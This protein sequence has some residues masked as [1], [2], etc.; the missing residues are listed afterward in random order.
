MLFVHETHTVRGN[1]RREFED[2]FRYEWMPTLARGDDARLLW[3]FDH[4]HG[5]AGSNIVITTTALRGGAALARLDARVR[6]GD[7]KPWRARVDDLCDD[8]VGRTM[9]PVS[10]SLMQEVD[11]ATV[12]SN[13]EQ[14]HDHTLYIEDNGWPHGPLN[15]YIRFQEVKWDKPFREGTAN[16]RIQIIMEGFMQVAHGSGRRPECMFIEKLTEDEHALVNNLLGTEL[17]DRMR[18]P[19]GYMVEGLKLRDNWVSK[20]VRTATWSPLF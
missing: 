17:P 5:T 8:S 3:Y 16:V 19:D 20:I 4:A 6:H 1:K 11:F 18:R 2:A 15:D 14:H 10:W 7:L 12:P 9:I 13:P